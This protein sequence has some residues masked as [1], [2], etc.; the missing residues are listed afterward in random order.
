M[1]SGIFS[2]HA[3]KLVEVAQLAASISEDV[4]GVRLVRLAAGQL[5][6]LYI[7]EEMITLSISDLNWPSLLFT[8]S[9][10]L[11]LNH[12]FIFVFRL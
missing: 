11:K 7:Q 5:G 4:A 1:C 9:Y 8:C 12:V 2:D 3:I 6:E 10:W